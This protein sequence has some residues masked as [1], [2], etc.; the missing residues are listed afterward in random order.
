[1]ENKIPEEW[2]EMVRS[3]ECSGKSASAW[4]KENGI[5]S[6]TFYYRRKKVKE[7]EKEEIGSVSEKNEVVRIEFK[8]EERTS[9]LPVVNNEKIRMIKGDVLF[10][11]P[12]SV[13]G[14]ILSAVMR[15]GGLC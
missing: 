10:E 5:A 12:L 3:Q 11:F 13:T 1:M 8:D 6:S 4:C 2:I 14:E 9:G 15:G 7:A